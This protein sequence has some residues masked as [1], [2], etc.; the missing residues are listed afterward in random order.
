METF[1]STQTINKQKG[2]K[3]MTEQINQI[4][5]E[6]EQP[7]QAS[8]TDG[9][10][11][12]LPPIQ[13]LTMERPATTNQT[14]TTLLDSGL[15][16]PNFYTKDEFFEQFKSVFQFG[17]D[18]FNIQSL[19]IQPNEEPG[20][21]VTSNRIYEMAEKYKFLQF[22]ID[23][24]STRLGETILM[25]QFLTSKAGAVYYEKKKQKLGGVL[26][27]KATKILKRNKGKDTAYSAQAVAEKQPAPANSSET[28]A[29]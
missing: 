9:M 13:P 4:Q 3:K 14:T 27:Q 28:A 15:S 24:R 10:T 5:P 18:T 8:I 1:L 25:I 2:N 11:D 20:A 23:K 29:A 19:P 17:G 16:N 22:M 12:N 6:T 21:R 7:A 26:W